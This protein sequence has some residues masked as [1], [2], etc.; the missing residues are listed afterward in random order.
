MSRPII[1][2]DEPVSAD[3]RHSRLALRDW[4][5]LG[6]LLAVVTFFVADWRG[7]FQIDYHLFSYQF[8]GLDWLFVYAFTVLVF[9]LL[10]P[11]AVERDRTRT[12][13]QRLRKDRWATTSFVVLVGFALLGLFGPLV[14]HPERALFGEMGP[15]GVP[16]TQPPVGF[17]IFRGGTC[18]GPTIDGRCFGSWQYPLGT[19][20][21][22]NDVFGMI[23]AGTRVALQ[24]SA[25][26]V[27]LIVPLATVVGTTAATYG[28]RIDEV[29]MRY[30]DI[31]QSIPAFFVIILAQEALGYINESTGGSLLLVVLVFG[32]MSWGGVARIIRSE[33]LELKDR[34]HVHAA[35]IAGMS[36]LEIVRTHIVPNTFSAIATA[37]TVQIGWLLLLETTLSFLGIG[38]KIHPSW[39]YVMT[40]S[41]RSGY[42]P[43]YHWWGVVFPTL[44]LLVAVIALQTFG[45]AIPDVTDPRMK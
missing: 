24:I 14:F 4:A 42:F 26:C 19:T 30:V 33:A 45:D 39:G 43:T 29:L 25:V 18:A 34:S 8:T 9:Y 12:Y 32:L 16:I 2:N 40:T 35:R 3:G 5:F 15:Y 10:V 7:A 1:E 41:A 21:G 11:L 28:G 6:V 17:S 23:V 20:P 38:S 22:A 36:R 31:Q 27:A 37:V 13:W 44:A